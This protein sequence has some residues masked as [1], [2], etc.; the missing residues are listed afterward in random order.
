VGDNLLIASQYLH[1]VRV[2]L[3]RAGLGGQKEAAKMSDE[4]P[5]T[6]LTSPYMRECQQSA[7]LMA[8]RFRERALLKEYLRACVCDACSIS[9]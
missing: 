7:A 1:A 3:H 5:V 2:A 6:F 8:V 4:G 9:V